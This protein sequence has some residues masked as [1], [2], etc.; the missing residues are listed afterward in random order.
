VLPSRTQDS[1]IT[2]LTVQ[3]NEITRR[4]TIE[5]AGPVGSAAWGPDGQ[6]LAYTVVRAADGR[7]IPP[8]D[9]SRAAARASAPTPPPVTVYGDENRAN[10]T[11]ETE[12]WLRDLDGESVGSARLLAKI[13]GSVGKG[14]IT[15]LQWFPNGQ[16]LLASARS[17]PEGSF[18]TRLHVIPR[19]GGASQ[20]I[21]SDPGAQYLNETVSPD[22]ES[23]AL[24]HDPTPSFY[25]GR[26]Q[27]ITISRT[28]GNLK[29]LWGGDFAP[30]LSGVSWFKGGDLW[31]WGKRGAF[32]ELFALPADRQS[33]KLTPLLEQKDG[34][35][36]EPTL[37]P[38]EKLW[39]WH[40]RDVHDRLLLRVATRR[41]TPIRT[42]V[43]FSPSIDTLALSKVEPITWR[44]RDGLEIAGVVTFPLGYR[45]GVRYPLIMDLHGGP[46]GGVD[47]RGRLTGSALEL[48]M[49]AAKG[50]VVFSPDWRGSGIYGFAELERR[51]V[52][53]DEEARDMD[54]I[55]SGVDALIERGLVDSS[56]MA[57]VGHSAGAS[58]V[59][60]LI[61][62]SS[63]FKAAISYDGISNRYTLF[64]VAGR[65]GNPSEEWKLNGLPWEVPENWLNGSARM[66]VKGVTTPTLFVSGGRSY[67][68]ADNAYLYSALRR[69]G[70]PAEHVIY[71][72]EGHVVVSP[73]NRRDLL[74][75]A[76]RWIETH[77]AHGNSAMSH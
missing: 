55:L 45:S 11:F 75:R 31:A 44:S 70:V 35:V 13:E 19:N 21:F 49:W 52:Q 34:A 65:A 71:N 64:A 46:A 63:R 69:Q 38:D 59:N 57:L 62:H 7:A 8:R 26:N 36:M 29:T 68:V 10:N 3:G 40:T 50:F 58:K 66:F 18:L 72:N 15:G 33:S 17:E 39:A 24:L 4:R 23:I 20:V 37:S 22:G 16:A 1:G 6:A 54:D 48:Q 67:V 14:W 51:R 42:L 76:I 32:R 74:M 25:P 9:I 28:G 2:L 47:P 12:V 27:V 43:S 56:R 60:W 61:T 77:L 30:R 5:T 53:Q 73:E 41:G